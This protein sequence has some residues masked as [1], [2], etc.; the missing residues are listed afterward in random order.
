MFI[1]K[2]FTR[3]SVDEICRRAGT[4]KGAFFHHFENKQEVGLLALDRFAQ[5]L[6][7]SLQNGATAEDPTQRLLDYLDRA[8]LVGDSVPPYPTCLLAVLTLE[9]AAA[10][11]TFRSASHKAFGRWLDDVEKLINEA[12]IASKKD[13]KP[14]EL[15]ELFVATL[16][17][18][19]IM[20]R[21]RGDHAIIEKNVASFREYMRLALS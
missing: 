12:A 9:L 14:R 16:E 5:L 3:S 4:T 11:P 6:T 19:L 20:A 15:A 7:D 10:N 1:E 21:A 13:L 8:M 18:S 17:G 2:G